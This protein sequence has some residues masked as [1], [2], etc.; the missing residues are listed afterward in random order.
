VYNPC[1][2]RPVRRAPALP[3]PE[4]LES[5]TGTLAQLR[6]RPEVSGAW[7]DYRL[8]VL[9]AQQR[10]LGALVL[11]APPPTAVA[12]SAL[13]SPEGLD[14]DPTWLLEL[15]AA[16]VGAAQE[17]G[18]PSEA[19]AGLQA[20]LEAQAGLGSELVRAALLQDH[21]ALTSLAGSTG[22]PP[23]SLALHGRMLAAPVVLRAVVA[24]TQAH[25]VEDG[26]GD[27]R[28]PFCG[29]GAV[30]ASLGRDGGARIL[31]CGLCGGAWSFR[32][33]ACCACGQDDQRQLG[34][35]II[36]EEDPAWIETCA[37][38]GVGVKTFDLR[39]IPG[40]FDPLAEDLVSLHLDLLAAREGVM[41]PPPSV[42]LI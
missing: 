15:S 30:L 5:L 6:V 35:L 22:L 28:C 7:L 10:A 12:G 24:I 14:L 2:P 9:G 19:L 37:A 36:G 13:V 11:H 42:A 31:H 18:E 17:Q 20:A 21:E 34:T 27:T 3:G 40:D 33:I 26:P 41:M 16:L 4:R 1:D 8:A 25:P 39:R 29:D 38:C 23:G 32:R